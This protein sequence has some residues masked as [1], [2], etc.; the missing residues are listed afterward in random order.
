M[1]QYH[2]VMNICSSPETKYF[3]IKM[4]AQTK[5]EDTFFLSDKATHESK[6]KQL[7]KNLEPMNVT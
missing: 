1:T 6:T 2:V 4:K 3:V 7:K 5:N